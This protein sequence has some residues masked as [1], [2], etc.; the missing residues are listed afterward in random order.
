VEQGQVAGTE[1]AA[2][3]GTG[4]AAVSV[5]LSADG[6]GVSLSVIVQEG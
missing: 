2:V 1:D 5:T 4:G 3:A 6:E